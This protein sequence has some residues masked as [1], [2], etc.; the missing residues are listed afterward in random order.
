MDFPHGQTV[1]RERRKATINPYSEAEA[2]GTWEDAEELDLTNAFVAAT[3]TS[4]VGPS[5]RAEVVTTKSLYLGDPSLDVKVGDRIRVGAA[6]YMV[7]ALPEADV[8][9]FTGWQ[10]VLEIPLRGVRG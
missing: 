3:S 2:P 7:D 4:G 10:P 8:N 6:Y 1:V 5:S 9:P